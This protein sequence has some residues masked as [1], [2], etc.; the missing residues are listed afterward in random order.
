MS[1]ELPELHF[2]S[3]KTFTHWNLLAHD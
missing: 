2:S 3:K 1:F